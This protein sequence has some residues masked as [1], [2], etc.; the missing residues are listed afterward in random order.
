ML[1][2]RAGM[3]SDMANLTGKTSLS[4]PLKCEHHGIAK[5]LSEHKSFIPTLDG[6]EFIALSSPELS[7]L[8]QSLP[9]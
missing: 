5:L 6:D 1:L 3:N 4:R 7:D 8:D 9:L 2:G